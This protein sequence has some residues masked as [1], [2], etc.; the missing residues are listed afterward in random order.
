MEDAKDL[1]ERLEALKSQKVV[2]ADTPTTGAAVSPDTNQ[3]EKTVETPEKPVVST[4][5]KPGETAGG[6]ASQVGLDIGTS[7]I[8][9]AQNKGTHID[10]VKQLNAF[11]TVPKSKFA[12][13]ILSNNEVMF[14]ESEGLFYIFGYSADSFAHMFNTNTK[15]PMKKGFL[16]A[17]E[18]ESTRIIEAITSS[19]IEKPKNFGETLCFAVPGEPL[20]GTGSVVYHESVVKNFLGGLGY[21][22]FP[23]NE[24]M[25]TCISELAEEDYT[26]IGISMGGGM[27]NVCLS[28]LSYPV[29]DYSLQIAGDYIDSMSSMSVGEP[30]TKIKSVKE[31]ELDLAENPTD[32]IS[33][34]LHI[35]YDDLILKLL[36]S[37]QRVL[38]S[39]D[40]VPKISKPIPIV[41]S[42]G[43]A[44]PNG[45]Q[46][47]F[48]NVL[49][50]TSLPVEISSVRI[51]E[52]PLNTTA[53]GALI[54]AITEAGK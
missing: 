53:K 26:G 32:R 24:G 42:G 51:A 4:E 20:K 45:L 7:H 10:A 31:T 48:E 16:S 38:T 11:F 52:D 33:T 3:Q 27:C 21:N 28:Y 18:K 40:K 46:A 12:E 30:A 34:A 23:I 14:Y 44:M 2:T 15:R 39:T 29:I 47:K 37:L 49:K 9:V 6:P 43:S 35:F 8:V 22:P 36:E 5:K 13:G 50:D 41:L 25:A 1:H 17:D 54:M 19:V